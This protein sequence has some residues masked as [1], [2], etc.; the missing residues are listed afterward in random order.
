MFTCT[1]PAL[2]SRSSVLFRISWQIFQKCNSKDIYEEIKGNLIKYELTA[3]YKQQSSTNKIKYREFNLVSQ[4][5]Q[6]V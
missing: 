2:K 4:I 3:K 1:W 6:Q 5:S